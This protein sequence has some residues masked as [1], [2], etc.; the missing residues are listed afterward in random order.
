MF[1]LM[2][3]GSAGYDQVLICF[4]T[5]LETPAPE[6]LAICAEVVLVKITGSHS[7][8]SSDRPM[9]PATTAALSGKERTTP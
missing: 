3:R 8:P 9:K 2:R 1:N 5:Q 7:R 4:A 6:L